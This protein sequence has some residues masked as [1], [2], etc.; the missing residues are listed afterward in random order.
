MRLDGY[1]SST[2]H[3]ET[4]HDTHKIRNDCRIS[5]NS[6]QPTMSAGAIKVIVVMVQGREQGGCSA[7]T[8]YLMVGRSRARGKL[9]GQGGEVR[10]GEWKQ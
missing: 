5:V 4:S 1:L 9:A 3:S 2:S 7:G 10:Q 8:N 6:K